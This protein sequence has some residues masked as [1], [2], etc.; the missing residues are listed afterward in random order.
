[1]CCAP[2]SGITGRSV[3]LSTTIFFPI[4]I[5]P[6]FRIYF[7]PF[8]LPVHRPP[9]PSVRCQSQGR[10]HGTQRAVI[11]RHG[12]DP[13]GVRVWGQETVESLKASHRPGRNVYHDGDSKFCDDDADR[14]SRLGRGAWLGRTSPAA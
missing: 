14:N 8:H 10:G 7:P 3:F 6:F 12:D 5:L 9:M 4:F 11:K 1:V 13:K 2:E